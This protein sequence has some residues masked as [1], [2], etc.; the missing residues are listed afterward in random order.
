MK[1]P[2]YRIIVEPISDEAINSFPEELRGGL[3]V[4]ATSS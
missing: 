3:S 4:R 1:N 2:N